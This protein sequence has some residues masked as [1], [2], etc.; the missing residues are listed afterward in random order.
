MGSRPLERWY[1]N[2]EGRMRRKPNKVNRHHLV[3]RTKGGTKSRDNLLR[4]HRYKHECWPF[5]FK[6]KTVDEIIVFLEK[7]PLLPKQRPVLWAIL[8]EGISVSDVIV[9][10]NDIESLRWM[11]AT[12]PDIDSIDFEKY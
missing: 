12:P 7:N 11:V 6:Q 1:A 2:I 3:P 8:F 10:L 9:M 4:S 5:L